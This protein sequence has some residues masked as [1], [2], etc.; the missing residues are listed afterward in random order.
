M[1]DYKI[2]FVRSGNHGQSPITAYQGASL[3]K[4]GVDVLYFDIKGKGFFGYLHNLFRLRKCIK[5]AKPELIHAHYSFS[6]FLAALTFCGKPVVISLMGSDVKSDRKFRFLIYIF[7]HLFWAKTIVKSADMQH[8]LGLKNVMVIPNGVDLDLFFEMDKIEARKKLNWPS[9]E[10][11]VLF[12][13][14]PNR[15]EKNFNLAKEAIRL[16]DSS[17]KIMYLNGVDPEQVNYY[18]NAAD[19][20]LLTSLWE[21]SPNV[22]KEAMAC[23]RPIITTNVGDV[24]WVIGKTSGC[25]VT[26][27]DATVIS[28]R[29]KYCLDHI[30]KSEGNTR[31]LDLKLDSISIAKRILEVYYQV[32]SK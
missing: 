11:I 28:E 8:V 26:N 3:K 22:V 19:V 20:V 1:A 25:Y 27:F 6:G 32:T 29:I 2:L 12:A 10:R 4:V 18:Y 16:A 24:S 15:P 5:T 17:I 31:I 13:S 7:Y 23:N 9:E 14:D 21:G 30:T